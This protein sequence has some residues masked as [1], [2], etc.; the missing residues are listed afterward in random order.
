MSRAEVFDE[1]TNGGTKK[2]NVLLFNFFYFLIR[3]VAPV[4]VLVLFITNL[5]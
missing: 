3:Y 2:R 4:G 1:L 5:L